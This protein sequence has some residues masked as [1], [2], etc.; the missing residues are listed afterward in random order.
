MKE[1]IDSYP[2][3]VADADENG[4]RRLDRE[5]HQHHEKNRQRSQDIGANRLGLRL[6]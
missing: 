1:D 2:G 4:R 6:L 5:M 3:I